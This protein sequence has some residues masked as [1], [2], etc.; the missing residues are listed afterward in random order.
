MKRNILSIGIIFLICLLASIYVLLNDIDYSPAPNLISNVKSLRPYKRKWHKTN[1]IPIHL[2]KGLDTLN[3]IRPY[4][5][6]LYGDNLYVVENEDSIKRFNLDGKYLNTIGYGK[7]KGPGEF[8]QIIDYYVRDSTIWLIDLKRLSIS[9]FTIDGDYKT[10]YPLKNIPF[11][12]VGENN[13]KLI[14]K[15]LYQPKLFCSYNTRGKLLDHFGVL[16]NNQEKNPFSFSG[17]LIPSPK[18]GFIFVSSLSS[19]IYYFN[20]QDSVNKIVTTPDGN[21][22]PSTINKSTNGREQ[23]T[24]PKPN[25]ITL[26]ATED[27][28]VLYLNTLIKKNSKSRIKVK[29]DTAILDRYNLKTGRYVSSTYLPFIPNY[30]QITGDTLFCLF[31]KSGRI[32]AYKME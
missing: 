13:H 23:F 18:K 32:K 5:L 7:G 17:W 15:V 3:L 24:A 6:K 21:P 27:K 28:N 1:F 20:A 19:L 31:R 10:T 29:K 9:K 22:F 16:A 8:E 25:I 30:I 12:I 26:N 11:R 4:G 14:I 2:R